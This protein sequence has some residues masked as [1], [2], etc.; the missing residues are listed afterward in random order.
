MK[1]L[2]RHGHAVLPDGIQPL[3]ILVEDGRIAALLP[4]GTEIQADRVIDA[5]GCYV[6]PGFIDF[7]VH[8]DDQI[9]AFYLADTYASGSQVAVQN[10]IT[11]LCSFV[12]QGR[13]ETLIQAL[14]TARQKAEGTTYADM[15]WHLTPTRFE[16]DDWA[17]I[18][19]LVALGYGTFKFYTT[20]KA[21]GIFADESQM[22]EVFCRLGPLGARI[23]V[24]CEDDDR[25]A[26]Q[27]ASKFDL[28]KPGSHALLRPEAAEVLAVE[29]LLDLAAH[30]KVSL[31]V[32]HVST[33]EAAVVGGP[34]CPDARAVWSKSW[35]WTRRGSSPR[36]GIG[37]LRKSLS[38]G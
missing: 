2:V 16:S 30:R 11:T 28:S 5:T 38:S 26:T 25:L 22:D 12:T 1:T 9:G 17:D 21:A 4:P 14:N 35:R 27:D 6:L 32:V 15:L 24:H 3:D 8:L 13:H 34:G 31:H 29:A 37:F 36:N 33:S 7:H 20:Y 10:G 19:N 18:E 23:L